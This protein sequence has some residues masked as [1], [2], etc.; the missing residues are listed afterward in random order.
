MTTTTP[1]ATAAPSAHEPIVSA[2]TW[3]FVVFLMLLNVFNILDRQLLPTFANEIKADLKLTNG[4]FGLLSGIMFTLLY[5]ILSPVM[6]MVADTVHRPRFA[7]MG[8]A[9]WSMLTAASGAAKGFISLAIPRVFIGVGEATITPTA[10]SMIADRFPARSLGLASGAYY[11]GVPLGAGLA[12]FVAST[13]GVAVGWR[14][15]FFIIGAVGI[16][17]A[18]ILAFQPDPRARPAASGG[19]GS[20]IRGMLA[21][22]PELFAAMRRSPALPLT[23]AGGVGLHFAVGGAQ[24]DTLWWKEELKLDIGPLFLKIALMYATVGVAGNILGGLAADWWLKVT[25]QGRPMFV[26]LLLLILTPFGFLYRL[27]DHPG[28]I[29]WL[30]VGT[31]I[32]QL[33][34]MYGAAYATISELAPPRIRA[35]AVAMFILSVNVIGLGISVTVGGFMIDAFAAA[36]RPKPITDMMLV[37]Q[38]A[39]AVAIPCFLFAAL[40]FTKDRQALAA[41]EAARSGA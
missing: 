18:L 7:A 5:G 29:F 20:A 33:A 6:G 1:E 32:F 24:F 39:S 35:T 27:T 14:Y 26:A 17:L 10:L 40:R 23:I 3:G 28:L 25:G 36:G 37:M 38:A 15:C 2:R 21:L 12:Y 41:Y 34:A 22:M 13:L 16:L 30:G 9:L 31:G 4:Q 8:V 11:A 19:A